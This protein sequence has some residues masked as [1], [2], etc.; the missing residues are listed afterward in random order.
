[1]LDNLDMRFANGEIS[2]DTY[3]SLTAK[4]QQRLKDMGG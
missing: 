2:E 4:W 1:M 3:K